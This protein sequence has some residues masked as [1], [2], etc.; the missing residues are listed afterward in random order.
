MMRKRA[1]RARAGPT[2]PRR[3]SSPAA[4]TRHAQHSPVLCERA[5]LSQQRL[6]K[7]RTTNMKRAPER[8]RLRRRGLCLLA[9]HQLPD[10]TVGQAKRRRTWTASQPTAIR[11]RVRRMPHHVKASPRAKRRNLARRIR[12]RSL[13]PGTR[14][15]IKLARVLRA[16]LRRILDGK[17]GQVH[18][19]QRVETSNVRIPGWLRT[20]LLLQRLP[21]SSPRSTKNLIRHRARIWR[22]DAEPLRTSS[23]SGIR[24]RTMKK[25]WLRRYS[26]TSCL[27]EAA[28]WRH[29]SA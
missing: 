4:R 25:S 16:A 20:L 14:S 2:L 23:S 3:T 29:D 1:R 9:M 21:I 15:N 28:I 19:A 27:G 18:L 5:G 8:P 7:M 10:A 24:T 22:L 26:A 13:E 6:A 17:A 12:R 11:S